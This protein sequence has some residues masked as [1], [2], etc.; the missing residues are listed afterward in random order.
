MNIWC[1]GKLVQEALRI[2]Y[3]PKTKFCKFPGKSHWHQCQ[4]SGNTFKVET[5]KRLHSL[6]LGMMVKSVDHELSLVV[7]IWCTYMD[8]LTVISKSV[9]TANVGMN[10]VNLRVGEM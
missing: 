2:R 6:A 1:C 8:N 5:I 4:W 9:A 10:E 7:Q 3:V